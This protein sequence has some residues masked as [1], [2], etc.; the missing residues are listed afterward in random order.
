MPRRDR[1]VDTHNASH[2]IK[3]LA[4]VSESF[5]PRQKLTS[6]ILPPSIPNI[7]NLFRGLFCRA[8]PYDA[9]KDAF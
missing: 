7:M 1:F 5:M 2:I 6:T 3:P 9:K 4:E 8:W